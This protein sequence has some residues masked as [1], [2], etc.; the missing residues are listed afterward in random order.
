METAVCG[1][2]TRC[3]SQ[4]HS[5]CRLVMCLIIK[6]LT[7]PSPLLVSWSKSY[8][9]YCLPSEPQLQLYKNN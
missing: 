4:P 5:L 3:V 2:F 6:Y 7:K 9:L 1:A 8:T